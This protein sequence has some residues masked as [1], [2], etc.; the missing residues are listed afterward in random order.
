MF[1]LPNTEKFIYVD[2]HYSILLVVL[3]IIIA[4]LASYTAI[5]LNERIISHSFFPRYIW[6]ILASISMG[7]GIWSMHFI[8]MSALQLPVKMEYD[9]LLTAI[10][11][12]PAMLASFLAFF[13]VSFPKQTLLT[14]SLSGVIMGI[15]ISFMHYLGM[16]AMKVEARYVYHFGYFVL[17][18]IIAILASFISLYVLTKLYK[19][20]NRIW[21]KL[22]ASLILGGAVASIH[23]TGMYA[24][25]YYVPKTKSI[26]HEHMHHMDMA[27]LIIT[28]TLGITVFLLLIFL[29]SLLDRYVDYRFNYFDALTK[30][31][32]RKQLEKILEIPNVSKGLAVMHLHEL[33]KWNN[34]FG[35]AFGDEIIK[36]IAYLCQ[37]IKPIKFSLYRLEGNRLAFLFDQGE[38]TA[39]INELKKLSETLSNPITVYEQTIYI[40]VA[41]AFSLPNETNKGKKILKEVNAVLSH[42]SIVYEH[43]IILYNPAIHQPS[44]DKRLIQDIDEAMKNNQLYLVYQPKIAAHNNKTLGVEALLRWQ[45]PEYGSLSPGIFIPIL[46]SGEK[47][48]DVTDWLINEVCKQ[49]VEWKKDGQEM[50]VAVNIPGT[51]VTAPRLLVFLKDCLKRYQLDTNVLEL[52]MTETSAVINIEAAIKSVSQFREYGFSVALDDF[53]TGVSS[54]SYLKRLPVSTLKIDK[55]FVDGI[56]NSQKDSEIIQ[57]IISLGQSLH[58]N[59]IIEGVEIKEQADFLASFNGSIGL[60]GF[61]FGKPMKV[62]ELEQWRKRSLPA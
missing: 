32:N 6:L 12:L 59:I 47:M 34:S 50:Q 48:F 49:I 61:Y 62:E 18:I 46:E 2:G 23:Y 37:Q 7:T 28:L 15:G 24:V 10:S 45:H 25:R 9:P 60:Q 16:M 27:I 26:S 44:F 38:S 57:A 35:Y 42:H 31:P 17:S 5:S 8:G 4:F 40:K 29:S 55:S 30:L 39:L 1:L 20:I 43:E 52:E 22:V 3:S 53:G 11:I 54:L 33:K 58:L 19:W 21:I 14:Y 41:T 36:H 13:L 56:P 51:Y